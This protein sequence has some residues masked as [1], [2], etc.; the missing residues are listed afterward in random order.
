MFVLMDPATTQIYT[1]GHPLALH[2]A[3]PIS[4]AHLAPRR[5]LH[6]RRRYRRPAGPARSADRV[7]EASRAARLVPG[8]PRRVPAA[9]RVHRIRQDQAAAGGDLSA[10]RLS[11][12]P[13][14]LDR[15]TVV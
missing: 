3:L 14:G 10:F 2:D 1:Y 6:H 4:P 11:S 5:P 15:K 9:A 8:Y 13:G 12:R 7:P